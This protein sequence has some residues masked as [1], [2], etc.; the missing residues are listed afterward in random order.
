VLKSRVSRE[1]GVVRLDDRARELGGGVYAELQLGL[2]PVVSREPFE[3]KC[4]EA[5]S[6]ATTE[7][8]EDEEALQT[9]AV[10]GQATQFVHDGV[11]EFLSY[12]V[13]TTGIWE[14]TGIEER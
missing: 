14:E 11:N 12:G 13:V 2:L 8:M 5:R 3:Q 4:T 1:N 7:G 6:S 10:V 9:R